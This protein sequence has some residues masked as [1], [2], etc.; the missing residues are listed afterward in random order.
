[1]DKSGAVM[2][3]VPYIIR[4]IVVL[5]LL[6]PLGW[7]IFQL[8]CWSFSAANYRNDLKPYFAYTPTGLTSI[9]S[10]VTLAQL[11][12]EIAAATLSEI[13][14]GIEMFV[15]RQSAIDLFEA[16]KNMKPKSTSEGFWPADKCNE[17]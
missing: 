17:D 13:M 15:D 2:K 8:L 6:V 12:G 14:S 4:T 9:P 16:V 3:I 7:F 1:M 11:L 5:V 10:P